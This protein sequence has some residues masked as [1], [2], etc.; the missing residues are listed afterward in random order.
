MNI[1]QAAKRSGL[2]DKTLRYYESI[3]LVSSQRA[4]NGYRNYE[5]AQINELRFLASARKVGFTI[6]ECRTL[7][8]LFRNQH[9]HSKHVK[10]FVLDKVSHIEEQIRTLETIKSSLL[11]LANQCRGDEEAQCAIIAG[12]SNGD[13]MS[14]K[15]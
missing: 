14:G 8:E 10:G 13:L 11:D 6:E 7:L 3:G 15:E 4:N 5:E 2:S 9:R 12:L 1:G